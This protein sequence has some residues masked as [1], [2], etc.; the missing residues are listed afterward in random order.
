MAATQCLTRAVSLACRE[1]D[2]R[3][4]DAPPPA[5]D[6]MPATLANALAGNSRNTGPKGVI[7]D[8]MREERRKQVLVRVRS[9]D[10]PAW[11][12]CGRS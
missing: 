1:R 2:R 5:P 3:A 7:E 6:G 4:P 12:R 10:A 8:Y 9:G 11:K